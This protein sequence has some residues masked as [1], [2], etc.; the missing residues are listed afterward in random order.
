ME[1]NG[2][3]GFPISRV[4]ELYEEEGINLTPEQAEKIL[5]FSQKLVNIVVTHYRTAT[6]TTVD[7]SVNS[8]EI[9]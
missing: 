8:E 6:Y 7:S 2:K 1:E 9:L 4:I 3:K 5:A